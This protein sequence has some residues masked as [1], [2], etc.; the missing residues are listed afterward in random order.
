[1]SADAEGGD[2][3]GFTEDLKGVP[4]EVRSAVHEADENLAEAVEAR[5]ALER[6]IDFRL[7]LAAAGV[8]LVVALLVRVL[9]NVGFLIS[10]VVFLVL[11]AG[12][13]VG[14]ARASMARRRTQRG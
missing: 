7:V 13:W 10:L 1:M 11:F 5:P 9:L 4:D 8:A 6:A 3:G 12:G 2:R 14:V